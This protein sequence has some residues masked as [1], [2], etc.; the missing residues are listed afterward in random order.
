M[1]P[2]HDAHPAPEPIAPPHGDLRNTLIVL[3]NLLQTLTDTTQSA[4]AIRATV[5]AAREGTGADAAFWYSRSG[6][7]AVGVSGPM[8]VEQCAQF[9]RK[10]LAAVPTHLD[11]FRWVNP[12]PSGPDQPTAALVARTPKSGGSV[13]L[14]SFATGRRFDTGD[15][16]VARMAVKMLVGM[17]AHA[18]VATKQILNGLIHSLTAV[19]DAKDP[20]TAGHSERVARIA[21]L[22][23]GQLGLSTA[24]TGDLFLAGLVHDLGKIGI[25]DEIL[26]KPA[27]LTE[28]EFDEVRRHPVIGERMVASIEPFRRLCPAVR[29]HHERYDGTGYPDRIAGEAI[30]LLG[31]VLAVADS[32][33]A[34]MSPRRYRPAR[35]PVE[36]DRV[37]EQETGKQ[38][39]PAIVAAFMAVRSQ[40]YPPIYQKGIGESAFHAIESIVENLTETTPALGSTPAGK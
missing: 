32:L 16:E 15:E 12:E 4:Q 19:L 8:S 34:M 39:D 21:V 24:V 25:R 38:F 35:S 11:V 37:F 30:P 14:L 2:S 1:I 27:K 23:G 9:A 6:T 5:E 22:L 13:V 28:A 17:R 31:R 40:I 7:K 26:F 29:H 33:D 20:Y 10:L 18:Q 3:E 36:I